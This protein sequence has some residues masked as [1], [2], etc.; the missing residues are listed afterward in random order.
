MI[1]PEQVLSRHSRETMILPAATQAFTQELTEI[2][3]EG[4]VTDSFTKAIRIAR[5]I[6]DS[7]L[8]PQDFHFGGTEILFNC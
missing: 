1:A 7:E 2:G 4:I 5:S 8:F 6:N 3:A